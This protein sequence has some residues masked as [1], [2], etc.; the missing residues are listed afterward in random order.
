AMHWRIDSWIRASCSRYWA[1][2]ASGSSPVSHPKK[3]ARVSPSESELCGW[4]SSV[5]LP[6]SVASG[7]APPPPHA[8]TTKAKIINRLNHFL[9]KP[10]PEVAARRD[11]D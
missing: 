9:M 4:D 10:P 5:S 2:E 3:A 7:A 6:E 11:V 8:D 1:S